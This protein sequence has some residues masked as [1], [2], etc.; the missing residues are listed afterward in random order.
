MPVVLFLLIESIMASSPLDRNRYGPWFGYFRS[1]I[2]FGSGS[3]PL[4]WNDALSFRNRIKLI[5]DQAFD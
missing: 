3:Q 5:C 2:Y 4:R 1:F